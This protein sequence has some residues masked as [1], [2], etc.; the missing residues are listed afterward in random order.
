MRRLLRERGSEESIRSI[1]LWGG[2]MWPRKKLTI[3]NLSE[4]RKKSID[5]P[6]ISGGNNGIRELA[7]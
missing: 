4:A 3:T 5:P 2:D 1:K 6:I 7:C